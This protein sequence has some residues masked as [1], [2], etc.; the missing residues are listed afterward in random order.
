MKKYVFNEKCIAVFYNKLLTEDENEREVDYALSPILLF[1]DFE[2]GVINGYLYKSGLL[3]C[4]HYDISSF[5]IKGYRDYD[6]SDPEHKKRYEYN[7]EGCCDFFDSLNSGDVITFTVH[8][9]IDEFQHF[10]DD[11]YDYSFDLDGMKITNPEI[12]HDKTAAEKICSLA[13]TSF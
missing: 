5:Q 3:L 12:Y 2:N 9:N 6:L 11:D 8:A 1:R 4:Y 13:N 7:T 10:H